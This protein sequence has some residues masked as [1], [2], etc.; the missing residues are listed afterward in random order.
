MYLIEKYFRLDPI[1][2]MLAQ[3][4][5]WSKWAQLQSNTR[6]WCAD[7]KKR[8]LNSLNLWA[9]YTK[10]ETNIFKQVLANYTMIYFPIYIGWLVGTNPDFNSPLLN[11]IIWHHNLPEIR[12]LSYNNIKSPA[13][14]SWHT[15]GM[16]NDTVG[17]ARVN[18]LQYKRGK[19]KS[20][21]RIFKSLAGSNLQHLSLEYSKV[22]KSCI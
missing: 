11:I 13:W 16:S 7:I 21:F 22:A 3:G 9:K 12:F 14:E 1:A 6:I 2:V 20:G 15:S 10:W 19:W 18:L 8:D 4:Y 17:V 5:N